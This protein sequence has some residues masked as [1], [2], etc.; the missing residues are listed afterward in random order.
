MKINEVVASFLESRS[1]R[2]LSDR[3]IDW[4][5]Q[6]LSIYVRFAESNNLNAFEPETVERFMS[7]QQAS[8]VSDSTVHARYRAIKALMRWVDK[9]HRR[10]RKV[11]DNPI[12]YVDSPSVAKR[13]PRVADRDILTRLIAS[14][15][16]DD[17]SD[18]RDKFTIRLLWST[19]IRVDEACNLELSDVDAV[20]RFVM[21]KGGKGGKD[22]ICPFDESFKTVFV[23]YVWNRPQTECKRLLLA[24][25]GHVEKFTTGLQPNGV[26]QMLR[27]RCV[28]AGI[29][30]INPHSI[31]H[32]Y[33]IER[34][35]NGMQLSAVSAAMGH[36]S[37]SFTAQHYAKWLS[38]GLRAEYD[39]AT[40]N[41]NA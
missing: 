38:T 11:F 39:K 13:K 8:S 17:F 32:L 30:I 41:L 9:R 29:A 1:A 35:N 21:V 24:C 26:R 7:S 5:R 34:L 3:T 36:S 27:R 33:A 2:N 10:T 19:G 23:E 16:S 37:V 20:Q 28:N 4:Y 14:I 6:Q 40:V 12:D 25:G 15:P 22:R 31:R 18:I